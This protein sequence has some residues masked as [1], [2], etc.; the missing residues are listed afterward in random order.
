MVEA[1]APKSD[2]AHAA[3][4]PGVRWRVN[5]RAVSNDFTKALTGWAVE[6]AL[7]QPAKCTL[8]FVEP[9]SAIL[10]A[11][12]EIELK[13]GRRAIFSGTVG[14]TINQLRADGLRLQTV[15]ALD[16]L[17]MLEQHQMLAAH[18]AGSLDQIA[19]DIFSKVGLKQ[20]VVGQKGPPMVR[21]IQWGKSDLCWIADLCATHGLYFAVADGAVAL[22]H[23]SGRGEAEV[24][25]EVG[26]NLYEYRVVEDVAIQGGHTLA[27]SSVAEDGSLLET[28]NEPGNPNGIQRSLAGGFGVA[29][30]ETLAQIA[31]AD[32]AR[33]QA[34]TRYV[35]GLA[36][37]N[38]ALALGQQVRVR[39]GD[40]A[41]DVVVTLTQVRH[42]MRTGSGFTTFFSSCPPPPPRK[43]GGQR[44][45]FGHVIDTDD[46]KKAGRVRISLDA[47]GKLETD[48]L[49]VCFAGAGKGKGFVTAPEKGDQVVVAFPNDNLAQGIVIG[50]IYGETKLP[51]SDVAGKRPRPYSLTTADG[52]CL[53]LDD[54]TQAASLRSKG[55]DL[56]LDPKK[57]VLRANTDLD[58]E[59]PGRRITIT[60]SH[61]DF[62][63]G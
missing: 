14:R 26:T 9:L 17:A 1:M 51:D 27:I 63:K 8:N 36:V 20:K 32:I 2:E 6:G 59:A 60:A 53:R 33:G 52:Q 19:A 45:G 47:F 25:L 43:D 46:P 15:E 44:V 21:Q 28:S 49:N 34:A 13:E 18:G 55:G 48:W 54:H 57:V 42:E 62:K 23:L 3:T 30:H 56:V 24:D 16:V 29:A 22:F 50:A 7:S 4:P 39:D 10:Q 37:G 40:A 38:S 35:E 61:I 41:L 58:I 31:K 11:G 5:G 12:D